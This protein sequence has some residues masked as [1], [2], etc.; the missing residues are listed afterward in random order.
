M[1]GCRFT[2]HDSNKVLLIGNLFKA[3]GQMTLL[4]LEI[5]KSKQGFIKEGS[6]ATNSF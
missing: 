6:S 5:H 2:V 4:G 1:L 3:R